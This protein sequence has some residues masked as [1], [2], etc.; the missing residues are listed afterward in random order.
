MAYSIPTFN[1]IRNLILQEVRNLTGITAPDDS[2]AAIRADGEAA[3]VEGLYQHQ[4]YIEKQLFVATADEPYLYVHAERLGLP[5]LGGT[6]ANGTVNA[7]SNADLTLTNTAKLTD[8]KGHYWSVTASVNFVANQAIDVQILA[9]EVGSAWNF[10]GAS[11]LWVAPEA[12]LQSTATVISITGGSD[13]EDLEDW[14]ARLLERQQLGLSRDREADLISAVQTV[15]GVR[16]VYVY[17]KRRGLGSVDVA[18]TADGDPATLPSQDLLNDVQEALDEYAGFW[19]D[20]YAYAPTVQN[21]NITAV[22]TGDADLEEVREVIRDYINAFAPADV[23]QAA[24]LTSR[25]LQV[26]NVS[27]VQ[28]SPSTNQSP[29]LNWQQTGWFRLGTLTVSQA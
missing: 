13:E 15:A 29:T 11:L 28:L 14:R 26:D 22:I 18:I 4:K 20:C 5:R 2:D 23:Y 19:A 3:V 17:P 9:D 7:T 25:I 12:G 27:D 21:L 16:D 24:V 6:R 1:Q 8:G 10:S